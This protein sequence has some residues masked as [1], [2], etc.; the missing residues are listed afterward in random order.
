MTKKDKNNESI[1]KK[2][3]PFHLEADKFVGK[4]TVSVSGVDVVE[5]FTDTKV[6][7]KI[8]KAPVKIIGEKLHITVFENNTIEIGGLIRGIEFV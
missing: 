5:E 8:G 7:F 6:I 3:S 4:F 2:A 1:N